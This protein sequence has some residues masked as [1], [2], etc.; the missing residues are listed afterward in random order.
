MGDGKVREKEIEE[1]GELSSSKTET[2]MHAK[3]DV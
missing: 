2:Q 1:F 3:R